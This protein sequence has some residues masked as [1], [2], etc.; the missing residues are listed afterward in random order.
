MVRDPV[1]MEWMTEPW[2]KARE[3]SAVNERRLIP[4]AME[5]MVFKVHRNCV[6][7]RV[8]EDAVTKEKVRLFTPLPTLISQSATF[9]DD[10]AMYKHADRAVMVLE[11]NVKVISVMVV[12]EWTTMLPAGAE[13]RRSLRTSTASF[14]SDPDPVIWYEGGESREVSLRRMRGESGEG[15]GYGAAGIVGKAARAVIAAV[16]AADREGRGKGLEEDA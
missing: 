13:L 1:F 2:A 10:S 6:M 16:V 11:M 8:P 5:K 15:V 9:G 3:E 4:A 7:V 12:G 14:P